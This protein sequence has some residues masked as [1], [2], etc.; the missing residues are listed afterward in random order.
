[1][2]KHMVAPR[3][4]ANKFIIW[5]RTLAPHSSYL[6]NRGRR[7][8]DFG[9]HKEVQP[10]RKVDRLAELQKVLDLSSAMPSDETFARQLRRKRIVM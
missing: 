3:L 8:R 6:S 2:S 4:M 5:T 9:L 10:P 7:G 1:M